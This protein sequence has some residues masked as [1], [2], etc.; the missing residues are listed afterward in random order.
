MNNCRLNHNVSDNNIGAAFCSGGVLSFRNTEISYNLAS[1][2]LAGI[3]VD[4]DGLIEC[5]DCNINCNISDAASN[6]ATYGAAVYAG[7][8]ASAHLIS[9][10][11]T[12]TITNNSAAFGGAVYVRNKG[13]ISIY[14]DVLIA[15]NRASLLGGGIMATNKSSVTL[16]PTNGFSPKVINN[17]ANENG[18]GAAI[19]GGSEITAVNSRFEGNLCSN[20]GG[21]MF[22]YE[23]T[24]TVYGAFS[25]GE[26]MPP[27]VF[28]DNNAR[29]GGAIYGRNSTLLN[30]SD[31][32]FVSNSA[33]AS[34]GGYGGAL[35]SVFSSIIDIE[36]S[37]IA[38]NSALNGG[39]GGAIYVSTLGF[40]D[41]KQCTVNNNSLHGITGN[42]ISITNSIIWGNDGMEISP[43]KDVNYCDV[44]GGYAT[45][46]GNLNVNPMFEDPAALNFRLAIGSP[47]ID[48][49]AVIN[50]NTDC[51]GNPRPMGLG[52]D[53][54]AYELDPT[55]ILDVTPLELDFGDV[56]LG[57]NADWPVT[58][59]N[60]GNSLL[61]GNVINIMTPPFS[62][63]SGSPYSLLPLSTNIVTFRYSPQFEV[64][65][66][67]IVTFQSNG[68]NINLKNA[69][70]NEIF[71]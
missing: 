4:S 60:L 58:V 49:G 56:V 52:F 13:Q 28:A 8:D 67:N 69:V 38:N 10:N 61:D 24:A 30:I 7:Q 44:D 40:L 27:C 9:L 5:I 32:L 11:D 70:E 20:S 12:F 54:G 68:G 3:G 34:G 14:G 43:G 18:G 15:N 53:L 29:H 45:G 65:R 36:N 2:S 37:I 1:N 35:Y 17:F 51:I 33:F 71:I 16:M 47:C 19:F 23:G 42:I 55:P 21:A 31:S 25:G 64:P 39:S 50:V 62:I 59:G 6:N 22:V 48:T 57:D 41:M 46:V 26:T 63:I 66:T